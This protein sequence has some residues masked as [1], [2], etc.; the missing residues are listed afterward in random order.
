MTY[1]PGI[2]FL[3]QSTT[4]IG[5]L[6]QLNT[7]LYD[8]QRQLTTQKKFDNISGFGA[9][10]YSVQKLRADKTQLNAFLTNI[11]TVKTRVQ[12]MSSSL[13][14]SSDAGRLMVDAV[15]TFYKYG[16]TDVDTVRLVARQQLDLMRDVAN[17]EVDG[18]YLF[19]GNATDQE[20]FSNYGQ[21]DLN[22]Q[23]LLGDW[24]AGSITT[25]QL[26]A[27]FDALS[28]TDLGFNPALSSAGKVTTQIDKSLNIDYTSIA[29]DN[30]MKDIMRALALAANLTPVD[31]ALAP[32]GPTQADQD[33]IIAHIVNVIEGGTAKTD[34]G[35]AQLGVHLATLETSETQ[36]LLDSALFDKILI[37]K[38]NA[39][40][41]EVVAKIQSL[42]TQL[43]SSYEITSLTSKLSLI[44]FI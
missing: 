44:N 41:T 7:T 29:T 34:R 11:S 17:L 8:L 1:T 26:I 28:D 16:A 5:R 39:D 9:Q 6:K 4:Q 43:T 24:Q 27:S 2:S 20:P 23:N 22:M 38:E 36:H 13:Q 18:R 37:D 21:L 10:A 3:G 33:A 31:P 25:A 12:V 30:G 40:T 19:A 35:N 15:S 14:Q 42:Q 32:P